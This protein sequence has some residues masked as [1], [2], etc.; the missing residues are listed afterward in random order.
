MREVLLIF[1]LICSTSIFVGCSEITNEKIQKHYCLL[2]VARQEQQDQHISNGILS[3]RQF[4]ISK[5]FHSKGLIYRIGQF[6]FETD[7]YNE[8]MIW[9]EDLITDLTKQWLAKSGIFASVVNPGTT[10]QPDYF[11]EADITALYGD[12]TDQQK[13]KAFMEIRFYLVQTGGL[14]PNVIHEKSYEAS[15]P[16]E[17]TYAAN[18]IVAYNAC[19]KQ[20]LSELENDLTSAI[21]TDN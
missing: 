17:D 12:F 14:K 11:L 15:I 9:T 16:L 21:R 5:R 4:D 3:V 19:L 1:L 6:E 10:A 13:P 2:D 7:Y 8:F 18:L 20:I